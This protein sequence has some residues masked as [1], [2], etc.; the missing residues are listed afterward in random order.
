MRRCVCDDYTFATPSDPPDLWDAD[1][2]CTRP[3]TRVLAAAS[4]TSPECVA[5][6]LHANAVAEFN[7]AENGDWDLIGPQHYTLPL[8]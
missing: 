5:C 3:A 2:Q 7:D 8:E 6:D 1:G 4:V